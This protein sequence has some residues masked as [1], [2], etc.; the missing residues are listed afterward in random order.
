MKNLSTKTVYHPLA[1][2]KTLQNTGRATRLHRE[3]RR[4]VESGEID[5]TDYSNW[6]KPFCSV[7]IPYWDKESQFTSNELARQIVDLRDNFGFDPTFYVSIGSDIGTGKKEDN[8]E[9]LNVKDEKNKKTEMIDKIY[10]EIEQIDKAKL[11]L[12]QKSKY[13]NMSMEEWFNFANK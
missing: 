2:T 7:I 1:L 4:R 8:L 12:I 13:D 3:D 11:A 6:I 10:H 9:Q 5:T